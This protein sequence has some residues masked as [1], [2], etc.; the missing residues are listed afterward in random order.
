[1]VI[2][3]LVP[4][5]GNVTVTEGDTARLVCKAAG[6]A[7]P[8]FKM[9][10]WINGSSYAIENIASMRGRMEVDTKLAPKKNEFFEHIVTIHNTRLQDAGQY[11]CRAGNFRG[12]V[13]KTTFLIVEQRKQKAGKSV[14]PEI[15]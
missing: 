8:H 10:K 14:S 5:L 12:V 3:P 6:D 15:Q 11:T 9:H 4:D 7:L 1:M 13:N 2:G